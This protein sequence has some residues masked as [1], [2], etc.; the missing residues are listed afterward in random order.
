MTEKRIAI[1]RLESAEECPFN[2]YFDWPD[3][4]SLP[5]NIRMY[6]YYCSKSE[7]PCQEKKW[8]FPE[9]CP[10]N[11]ETKSRYCEVC[12]TEH[13]PIPPLKSECHP[14][15]GTVSYEEWLIIEANQ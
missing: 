6:G 5:E 15:K 1:V 9:H 4:I 11:S 14:G 7:K 8:A 3:T 13:H 12:G 2:Y 10:L